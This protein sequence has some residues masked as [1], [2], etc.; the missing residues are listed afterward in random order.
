M[1]SWSTASQEGA[2]RLGYW[3]DAICEAI[4]ELDFASADE[5]I[6]ARMRQHDLGPL[7]LSDISISS[8][9]SVTRS[10][11]AAA[12]ERRP[13]LNL[14]WVRSGAWQVEHYG[15]TIDLA[16]G[17]MVLLD[18][19]QPYSVTARQGSLHMVARLPIEWIRCWLPTPEAAVARPVRAGDPWHGALVATLDE[20]MRDERDDEAWRK[21]CT[22]QIGGALALTLGAAESQLS[23]HT[24]Q[25]YRRIQGAI[26]ERFFEHDLDAA[27]IAA[28][29]SISPRYLHKILAQEG[30]TYVQEL[31][32]VRLRHACDLLGDTRF[33]ALSVSEIGWRSGFCD[34]SHFSRR[35]KSRFGQSPGQWRGHDQAH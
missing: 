30:T 13:H 24:R 28:A 20:A 27:A 19:R 5:G 23:N 9:H 22:Q 10:H 12:R 34:P 11:R 7:Q 21:L 25:L 18:N 8:P 31:F 15:R 26:Q 17:D 29:V 14:N 32:S 33:A 4:F 3:R 1:R 16:A 2:N 6:E 35:F